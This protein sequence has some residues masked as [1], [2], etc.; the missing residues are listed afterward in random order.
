M[1]KIVPDY[2]RIYSDIITKEFP[3]KRN[4]CLQLLQKE[5]LSAIDIIRLNEEIFGIPD[6]ETFI[7]NQRHRSYRETDILQI[8]DYQ[9]RNQLTN[10]QLASHFKLS[11]NTV[12]KWRK[13]FRI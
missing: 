1:K 3:D 2:K 8:L 9:Q 4:C 5:I 6:K 11:R 7:A 12:A 10:T 13:K